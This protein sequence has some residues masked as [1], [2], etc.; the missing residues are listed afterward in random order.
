MPAP[1]P[2]DPIADLAIPS[3]GLD[4]IVAEGPSS[5]R[6]APVHLATTALPGYPGLAAVEAGRL[7]YGSFFGSLD[8]L[9]TGDEIDVRTVAG[10]VRYEVT[11]V[12][13]VDPSSID[14]TSDGDAPVL[15]LIAP[16]SRIG[17]GLR[18]VVRASV[19]TPAPA[20]QGSA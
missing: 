20:Y 11:D 18:L 9:Q 2:G 15:V 14:L 17:G 6:R 10:V 16:S 12:S 7:G 1:R 19:Q 8:R 3:L 4:A 5:E 13:I